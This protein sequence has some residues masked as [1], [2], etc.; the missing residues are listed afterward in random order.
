[1]FILQFGNEPQPSHLPA[2]SSVMVVQLLQVPPRYMF[3]IA[4]HRQRYVHI[5]IKHRHTHRKRFYNDL[6]Q[7]DLFGLHQQFRA[8]FSKCGGSDMKNKGRGLSLA[9]MLVTL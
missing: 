2:S 4:L 7:R 8:V 6:T 9:K 5:F 1:M 3:A